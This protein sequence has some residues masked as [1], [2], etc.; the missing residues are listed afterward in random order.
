MDTQPQGSGFQIVPTEIATGTVTTP[1]IVITLISLN[2]A[3]RISQLANLPWIRST[4][5]VKEAC[6]G[7]VI[8]TALALILPADYVVSVSSANC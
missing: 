8:T 1:L 4:Q 5:R 7:I 2:T 3:V 6:T